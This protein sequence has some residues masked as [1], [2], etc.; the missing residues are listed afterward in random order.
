MERA[1]EKNKIIGGV[2]ADDNYWAALED[3]EFKLCRC[4]KCQAWMWPAHYRC[5]CGSWDFSW[6]KLEPRG[7]IYS[8]VRTHYPFDRIQARAKDVPFVSVLAEIPE[9]GNVR[10]MGVLNGSEEGLRIGARVRGIILPPSEK[11]LGYA[12]ITWRIEK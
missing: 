12:S 5:P 3:G 2:S 11:A 1:F 6:V 8:W 4:A 10:V 7:N 9:A